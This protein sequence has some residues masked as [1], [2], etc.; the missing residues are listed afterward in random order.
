MII[1]IMIRLGRSSIK[2]SFGSCQNNI[3]WINID[4]SMMK[5]PRHI[6][7]SLILII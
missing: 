2:R 4:E 6:L 1:E 3:E 7:N 5:H